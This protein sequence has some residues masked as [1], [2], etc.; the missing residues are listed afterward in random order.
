MVSFFMSKYVDSTKVKV[1]G[2]DVL[3]NLIE[4][5]LMKNISMRREK[6]SFRH[7]C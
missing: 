1:V 3:V 2:V 5:Y 4:S 6:I 7:K